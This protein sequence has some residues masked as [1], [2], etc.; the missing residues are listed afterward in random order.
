[1][2]GSMQ[3][4]DMALINIYTPNTGSPKRKKQ[5]LT[6]IKEEIDDNTIIVD[7]GRD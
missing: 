4:K 5:T 7:G 6:D 2:K 3:E 1:M